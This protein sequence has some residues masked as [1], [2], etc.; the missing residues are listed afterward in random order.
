MASS[1]LPPP[2]TTPDSNPLV[3]AEPWSTLPTFPP[4]T[5]YFA[6]SNDSDSSSSSS[7]TFG[8]IIGITVGVLAIIIL[9]GIWYKYL[10]KR[11]HASDRCSK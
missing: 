6:S 4:P 5:S 2:N 8:I 11:C 9:F 3:P 1:Y 10:K 7:S